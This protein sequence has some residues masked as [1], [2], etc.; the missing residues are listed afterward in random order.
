MMSLS[1]AGEIRLTRGDTFSMPIV[2]NQGTNMVPIRYVLNEKD[3]V[4]FGVM[5]PNQPFEV[6]L[7]RKKYTK[8]DLNE[9]G[10]V[11]LRLRHED[12]VCLLP[13]KYYYQ[14]KVRLYNNN[15][16]E[17]DVNTIIGKTPFYIE[18]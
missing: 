9:D 17:Y 15:I 13:G 14:V 12:T 7:I 4:Y 1:G 16:Q 3:E 8:A 10:D 5:E 11:Q 6:A 18:E 2:I